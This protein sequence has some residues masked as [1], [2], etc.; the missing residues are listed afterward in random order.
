MP[1]SHSSL[2]MSFTTAV[3]VIH[4]LGSS[5]FAICFGFSAIVMYDA[6]NVRLQA[7][8][9]AQIL[10][11]VV[12]QTDWLEELRTKLRCW[13]TPDPGAGGVCVGNSR[14]AR[15][16]LNGMVVVGPTCNT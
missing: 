10:N 13:D 5:I 14:R 11:K 15:A 6:A 4:G 12:E 1:S 7:G 16:Q 9:H 8:K 2:C 3:G